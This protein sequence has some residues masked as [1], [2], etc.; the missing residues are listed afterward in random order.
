MV[1]R[2]PEAARIREKPFH[3]ITSQNGIRHRRVEVRHQV[4]LRHD[5]QIGQTIVGLGQ[6]SIEIAI[7]GRPLSSYR[8]Q[9]FQPMSGDTF[10]IRN[11]RLRGGPDLPRC[12]ER[13]R[14]IEEARQLIGAIS[15]LLDTLEIHG[16]SDRPRRGRAGT[17]SNTPWSLAS[18]RTAPSAM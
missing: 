4:T 7:E 18:S 15:R 12:F 13:L 8:D 1:E 6:A 14:D 10:K 5:R 17:V 2:M 16:V 11:S 9:L 3:P